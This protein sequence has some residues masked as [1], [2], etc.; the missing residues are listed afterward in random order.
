MLS[1]LVNGALSLTV[2]SAINQTTIGDDGLVLDAEVGA[3]LACHLFSDDFTLFEIPHDIDDD[4]PN[5]RNYHTASSIEFKYCEYLDG[6][7]T[8]ARIQ[9]NSGPT[10][11]YIEITDSSYIP[12]KVE[13]VT[14]PPASAQDEAQRK[15]EIYGVKITRHSDT[16][17]QVNDT[18]DASYWSFENTILC[19]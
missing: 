17:C 10:T 18:P 19:D 11:T 4:I 6:T 3:K 9:D 2:A 7:D 12:E 15:D 8:F 14:T 1:K 16:V 13:A 5:G